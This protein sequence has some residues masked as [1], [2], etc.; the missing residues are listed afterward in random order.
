MQNVCIFQIRRLSP[1]DSKLTSNLE[2]EA[3]E[4]DFDASLSH[5]I[6]RLT[7][8]SKCLSLYPLHAACHDIDK[9]VTARFP[10]ACVITMLIDSG[11]DVN[12]KN[13]LGML[14]KDYQMT[15]LLLYQKRSQ[16]QDSFMNLRC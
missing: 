9:P 3:D 16:I 11:I 8:V 4:K 2:T 13:S 6:T 7:L 12:T 5:I 10:C 14:I 15:V 1:S